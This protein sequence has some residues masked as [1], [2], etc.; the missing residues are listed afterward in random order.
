MPELSRFYGIVI[1][2]FY[3][4]HPPPHFHAVYQ[5]EQV[6]VDIH[7]PEIIA[8][9]M[10]PRALALI[11]EWAALHRAELR[12]A[13][14]LTSTNREAFKTAPLEQNDGMIRIVSAE[15][16]PGCRLKVVFSDGLSGIFAVEPERRGGVFLKL[17]DPRVFNAVAVNPDFGCV[18]WPGGIDLCPDTMHQVV[19]GAEPKA[20]LHS[21]AALRD[22]G[23][24][25]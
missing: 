8:G 2:M 24:K 16:L 20:T 17:L 7:T 12:R 22:E 19:A 9:R 1:R 25:Q 6:R 3:G 18:E 14:E 4:D 15:A 5:E 11:L 23:K 21:P 13:W 10:T